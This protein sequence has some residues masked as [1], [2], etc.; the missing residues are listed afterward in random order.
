M[1]MIWNL[2]SKFFAVVFYQPVFNLLIGLVVFLPGHDMGIAIILLTV[3]VKLILWPFS[4]K[5]LHSQ[6][7]LA[8]MQPKVDA[9]KKEYGDK[10]EEL[11]KAMMALYSKEKVS[12]FSSCGLVLLQLPVFI[13]LY[14]ALG[15]GLQ[16]SGFDQLYSFIPNPG[17]IPPTL[18]GMVNLADPNY[19][20][21]IL[22]GIIQYFQAK[23]MI[24]RQQANRG[25]PGAS[26]EQMLA[27]M[28]KQML[29]VMPVLTVI[30]G[31][32]LPGGLALYWTVT[33]LLTVAQ[34]EFYFHKKSKAAL[35][36]T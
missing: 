8:D 6:K 32:T 35:K 7:A 31:W 29:Y 16:S 30:L 12:P 36:V 2:I 33:N 15:K 22:A 19:P 25:T 18:L 21:A 26:D 13:S 9:L 27:T 3:L 34:Q 17:T 28:N 4:D 5:A 14:H 20:L 10:Q 1:I 23:S 11:A 24:T